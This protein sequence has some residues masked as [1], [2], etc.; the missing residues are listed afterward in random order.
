[1]ANLGPT[2]TTGE[3]HLALPAAEAVLYL[4]LQVTSINVAQTRV[5]GSMVP[6]GLWH[7]GEAGLGSWPDDV[8]A[9]NP[10][11]IVFSRFLHAEFERWSLPPAVSGTQFAPSIF[12][13]WLPGV[14]VVMDVFW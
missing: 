5:V 8:W 13:R 10:P 12:W 9:R 3:G 11:I 7:L 2:S 1:M 4:E 14:T 6:R